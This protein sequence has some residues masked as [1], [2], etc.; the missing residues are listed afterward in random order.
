MRTLRIIGG[1]SM[2][3]IGLLGIGVGTLSLLDPVGS[4]MADD[5]DPFGP[6]PTFTENISVLSVYLVVMIL[7]LWLVFSRRWKKK[8][9][10]N[11]PLQR[12]DSS[13]D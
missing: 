12:S 11:N 3:I 10:H 4:K 1:S 5:A 13:R 2:L 9:T 6:P 7:G 8:A